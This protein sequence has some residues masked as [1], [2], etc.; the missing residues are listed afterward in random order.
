MTRT[1]RGNKGKPPRR[2]SVRAVRRN[3][4]DISKLSRALMLEALKQAAAEAAAEQQ[5]T[6]KGS[7]TPASDEGAPDA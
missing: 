5:A 1:Q 3:P 7:A 6:A 4:P 2:I